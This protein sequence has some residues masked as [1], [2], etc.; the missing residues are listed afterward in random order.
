MAEWS[1]LTIDQTDSNVKVTGSSGRLLASIQ[2]APKSGN[3][4]NEGG[5]GGMRMQP[6]VAQWQG[7][8]LVAKNQGFGGGTTTRAFELSPDGK[9]LVVTT[10]IE[11]QRFNEPVTYKQVYDNGKAGG[12]SQ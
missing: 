11:N 5:M 10:K 7:N 12:N 8:Q 4:D 2:P 1:Q 9:Q 3:N 6:A